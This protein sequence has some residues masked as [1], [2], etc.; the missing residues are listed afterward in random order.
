MLGLRLSCDE[1]AP[2]AG[3]TP[4]MAAEQAA[5]LA[6]RADYLVVVRGSIYSVPATRPDLHTEP[7]PG[8]ELCRQVRAAVAGAVPVALQGS[9]VD[10]GQA[11]WALDDGVADLAEMT[12][13][14]I[15]DPDL[16]VRL[17]SGE[18]ERIRPCL[19]CNQACMVRD[20]R[21]P[22]ITC[23]IE[24]SSG[25]ELDDG[26]TRPSPIRPPARCWSSAAGPPAWKPPACW[27]RGG[28]GFSWP[29]AG[30]SWAAC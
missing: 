20:N 21:N 27:R 11:Q 8:I 14:Q 9:V 30:R 4:E 12:R 29:N 15:T 17:R 23:V 2:W 1:L 5:R 16:V 13:A 10:P 26:E 6:G 18:A 22:V 3:V 24:P 25:H 19:L 7:G 28:T